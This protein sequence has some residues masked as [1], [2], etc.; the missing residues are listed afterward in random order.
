MRKILTTV[1]LCMLALL[2]CA[3]C[4]CSLFG[5]SKLTFVE[6]GDGYAVSGR[7]DDTNTALEIPAEYKGKPVVAIGSEAF[8]V[9]YMDEAPKLQSVT[10]PDTVTTIGARAFS[11]CDELTS[12]VI[13]EG[14]TTI[15]AYTFAGCTSLTSVTLPST[16]TKIGQGAFSGCTALAN[17]NIPAS[18]TIIDTQAFEGCSSLGEI[19]LPDGLIAIGIN[20]FEGC[21]NL[22]ISSLPDSLLEIADYAFEGCTALTGELTIPNTT[23]I[24]GTGIF[25]ETSE[26]LVVKVSYD[27]QPPENWSETWYGG[28][29]GKA[30][31]TSD[32][33]YQNVVVPNQEATK[34]LQEAIES[35]KA[36]Y[37]AYNE[38]IEGM[39]AVLN[40]MKSN[41]A[42][43]PSEYQLQAIYDYQ[44]QI[45]DTKRAQSDLA[46][47]I[48]EKEEELKAYKITN[49]LN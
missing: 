39:V 6:E 11:G 27:A 26:D 3:L 1:S 42:I 2:L 33:Y 8:A 21:A 4:S 47:L 35:L 43:N 18:V 20:T 29:A 17:I 23:E 12:V 48:S 7:G 9:S 37:E 19:T 45:N 41:A 5:G 15:Q 38:T 10:I 44:D 16:V 40:T 25:N 32:V 36:S 28:M 49:Q 46:R 30:I 24:L 31:N 13:P 34:G 22:K 14:V